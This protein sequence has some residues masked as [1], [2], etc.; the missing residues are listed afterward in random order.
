M[1]VHRLF[2]QS[3]IK[4]NYIK[5]KLNDYLLQYK[6]FTEIYV[7]LQNIKQNIKT[8]IYI[9]FNDKIVYAIILYFISQCKY[10][11]IK[12]E[13]YRTNVYIPHFA[14]SHEIFCVYRLFSRQVCECIVSAT[15]HLIIHRRTRIIIVQF[16]CNIARIIVIRATTLP[17]ASV[18]PS[19]VQFFSASFSRTRSVPIDSAYL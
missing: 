1:S 13:P 9:L 16:F 10:P 19:N 11:N 18:I 12:I 14:K 6:S 17:S 5:T 4:Y 8:E 3:A 2:Y 7:A 15:I